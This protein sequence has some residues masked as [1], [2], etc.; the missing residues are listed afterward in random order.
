MLPDTDPLLQR[1]RDRDPA[2]LGEFLDRHRPQLLAY[3]DRQLGAPL[4]GKVESQ[5]IF[6]EVSVSALN[7]LPNTDLSGRDPFGWLCQLAEQ[8]IIDAYRKFYGARKRAADREVALDAPAGVDGQ[9]ALIDLLVLS[10]TTPSQACARGERQLQL[11]GALETLPAEA[12]EALR[13][14]YAEGLPTREIAERIGK[15]DAAVR[16]LLSRSLSRLRD[17][18]GP[19]AAP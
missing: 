15:S 17:L 16:V 6:Q 3:I 12:R 7:A 19:E 10:L 11:A 18:L 8:R 4:R 5:D 1:L 9:A 14:R 2:A 13:L